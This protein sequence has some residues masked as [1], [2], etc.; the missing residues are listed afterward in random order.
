LKF[1]IPEENLLLPNRRHSDSQQPALSKAE[2]VRISVVALALA[3]APFVVIP[4]GN[5]L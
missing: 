1:V 5:L 3:P 4:E 2:W